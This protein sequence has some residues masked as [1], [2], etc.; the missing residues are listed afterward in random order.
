MELKEKAQLLKRT[1]LD[2]YEYKESYD[3]I[4]DRPNGINTKGQIPDVI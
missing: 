4:K 1:I 2:S 3:K